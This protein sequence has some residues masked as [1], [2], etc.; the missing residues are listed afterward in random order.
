[1]IHGIRAFLP[2]MIG[3]GEGYIV[4]TASIAGLLPGGLASYD[5]TKHAVVAISE[6]L[7]RTMRLAS[8]PVGVSVLCPGLVRTSIV[9]AERNWPADLGAVPPHGNEEVTFQSLQRAVEEE[10]IAPAVVADLV[11]DAVAAERF[12]V[13]TD[14]QSV[15]AAAR[16]WHGI[17]E[18][19][20]PD[21]Q[22][23]P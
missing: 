23:D 18:G 5:G 22:M 15:D 12:W 16:R 21:L 8:H 4:N 11:A 19:R 3:Q 6:D 10:G 17:A 13:F 7:Y 14:Q 2:V 9:D 20:N 1:V